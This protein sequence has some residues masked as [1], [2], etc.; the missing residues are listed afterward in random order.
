[1][2]AMFRM[3]GAEDIY[4]KAIAPIGFSSV[5]ER[6]SV[7]ETGAKQFL[8]ALDDDP[9]RAEEKCARLREKMVFYFRKNHATSPEDLAQEVFLRARNRLDEGQVIYAEQPESYFYGIARNLLREDWKRVA[10]QPGEL[11]ED[12]TDGSRDVKRIE[13]QVILQDCLQH[14]ETEELVFLKRYIH[15]GAGKAAQACGVTTNAASIR[16]HRLV[17][18]LRDSVQKIPQSR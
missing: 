13:R 1:M 11:P 7:T 3:P 15:E 16:F 17:A 5:I 8:A 9:V 12:I 4:S 2:V 6:G 18:K 10:R 14:L